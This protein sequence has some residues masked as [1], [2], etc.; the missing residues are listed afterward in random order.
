M[1]AADVILLVH[2]AADNDNATRQN[3]QQVVVLTAFVSA[4]DDDVLCFL[5]NNVRCVLL[6]SLKTMAGT[7]AKLGRCCA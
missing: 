7:N 6:Q 4:T 1:S 3:F 5:R 2:D